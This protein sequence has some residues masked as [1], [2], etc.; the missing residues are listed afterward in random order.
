MGDRPQSSEDSDY[1]KP[2]TSEEIEDFASFKSEDDN[3]EHANTLINTFSPNNLIDINVTTTFDDVI[4]Q[5]TFLPEL[6]KG[7]KKEKP[8]RVVEP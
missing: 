2:D 1:V 4:R 5:D 8:T 6:E 3:D 7:K